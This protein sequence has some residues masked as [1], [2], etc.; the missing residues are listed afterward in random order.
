MQT[1]AEVAHTF[2]SLRRLR[3]R[4]EP[5]KSIPR[6]NTGTAFGRAG[7]LQLRRAVIA[8]IDFPTRRHHICP[9]TGWQELV[10]RRIQ[11]DD[12]AVSF[13]LCR[14][15]SAHGSRFYK[16]KR[17][18]LSVY[19]VSLYSFA[20][21]KLFMMQILPYDGT[22]RTTPKKA[23]EG[24]A[25]AKFNFIAQTNLELSLVKG[26]LWVEKFFFFF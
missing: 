14:G 13:Q 23:H 9:T 26:E 18:K 7:S 3:G 25:R 10:R 16:Y 11:C 15:K 5:A 8:G 19:V 22:M 21:Y 2:E 1:L 24:Q 6:S 20:L 12:R 4:S 17:E